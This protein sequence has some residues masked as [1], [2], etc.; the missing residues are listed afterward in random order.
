M[1]PLHI[2]HKCFTIFHTIISIGSTTIPFS[3]FPFFLLI[4]TPSFLCQL[5]FVFFFKCFKICLCLASVFKVNIE[6]FNLLL[7]FDSKPSMSFSRLVLPLQ[8]KAPFC[9]LNTCLSFGLHLLKFNNF[10]FDFAIKK[11][12][13]SFS[14]CG[15]L[16][17]FLILSITDFGR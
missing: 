8:L 6:Q 16:I 1:H 3:K 17:V 4:S 2:V 14:T 7:F 5:F 11:S 12:A 13:S 10:N 15:V 9:L